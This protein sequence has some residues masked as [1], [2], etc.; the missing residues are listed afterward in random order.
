MR[1]A[2][3]VATDKTPGRVDAAGLVT[4]A[5]AKRKPW[6]APVWMPAFG[7]HQQTSGSAHAERNFAF[8]AAGRTPA[9]IFQARIAPR[10]FGDQ[11]LHRHVVEGA[12]HDF[13]AHEGPAIAAI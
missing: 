10:H 3:N 12:V 11:E 2:L 5:G 13:V 4:R 1:T 7:R 9:R 6:P 8:H